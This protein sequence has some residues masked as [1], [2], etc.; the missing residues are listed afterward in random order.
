MM[1]KNHNAV[2]K[3]LIKHPDRMNSLKQLTQSQNE[4]GKLGCF[5]IKQSFEKYHRIF[6][7]DWFAGNNSVFTI[8]QILCE[9]IT[10]M[11]SIKPDFGKRKA[12]EVGKIRP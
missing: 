2:F 1:P 11:L 7:A 8:S 4:S 5:N 10:F 9:G 12:F 6:H 3:N